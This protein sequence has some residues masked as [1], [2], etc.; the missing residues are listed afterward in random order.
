MRWNSVHGGYF[1]D[2]SVAAHLVSKVREIASASRPDTIVDLG[3]GTGFLLSNLR[4][5]GL[6][7]GVSLVD[8]DESHIQLDAAKSPCFSCLLGAVESFSRHD[9]GPEENRYLFMMRSVLHYFGKDG[10]RPLLRH[11]RAQARP[12]EFFVHQ[13]ASFRRR[14][15]ATSLN[16]L[17]GMMKTGKWYPTAT[18]LCRALRL[19]GW[20]VVEV[21]PASPLPLN[22]DDLMQRYNLDRACIRHIRD[23]LSRRADVPE[24][25]FKRT[26]S[27]FTAFLHY[28]TYVCTPIAAD[29]KRAARRPKSA[30]GQNVTT[31]Q[32]FQKQ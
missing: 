7:A 24:D 1:S 28:W 29:A 6:D 20:K 26:G 31:A 17:Y 8:L 13:T 19:E 4:A 12:G 9:V 22:D 11:L 2:P 25:V 10:L 5:A 14:Q 15:D 21:C 30:N 16:S 3:G 32:A 23:R 18:F 27:G